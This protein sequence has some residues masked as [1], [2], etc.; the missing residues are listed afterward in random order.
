[1]RSV[2]HGPDR[3]GERIDSQRL[4]TNCGSLEQRK[5]NQRALQARRIGVKDVIAVN[6][7]ADKRKLRTTRRVSEQLRHVTQASYAQ[8]LP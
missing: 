3:I 6:R 5:P 4:A 1:M 2:K 8:T 7:Q